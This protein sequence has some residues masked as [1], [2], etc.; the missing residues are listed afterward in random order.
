MI[1]IWSYFHTTWCHCSRPWCTFSANWLQ[2]Y[3][4]TLTSLCV[5]NWNF[6]FIINIFSNAATKWWNVYIFQ[7]SKCPCSLRCW[8]CS[9]SWITLVALTCH[10]KPWC[11]ASSQRL[12]A[13]RRHISDLGD[14]LAKA[15]YVIILLVGDWIDLWCFLIRKN[16]NSIA[17]TLQV[18]KTVMTVLP[19]LFLHMFSQQRLLHA[20]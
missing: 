20:P 4:W 12:G 7:F 10:L 18:V 13:Y 9:Q 1:L 2:K 14:I 15:D 17:M 8:A 19:T 3:H 16:Q 5:Q 6:V 11:R